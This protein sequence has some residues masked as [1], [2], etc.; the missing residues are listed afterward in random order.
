MPRCH[1]KNIINNSQ[2]NMLPP[3]PSYHA[4]ESPEYF[5]ATESQEK[6]LKPNFIKMIELLKEEIN[7]S[8]KNHGK[9]KLKIGGNS[10]LTH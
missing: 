9:Y 6:D 1:F 3:E 10:L 7:K 4:T 8:L 2:G 5:K